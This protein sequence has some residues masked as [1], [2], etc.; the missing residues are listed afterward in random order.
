MDITRF[1]RSSQLPVTDGHFVTT[2]VFFFAVWKHLQSICWVRN[3]PGGAGQYHSCWFNGSL[4]CL[5]INNHIS[6]YAQWTDL[7]FACG[8]ITSTHFNV[9]LW[10]KIQI[11]FML[12]HNNSTCIMI[13]H[14]EAGGACMGQLYNWPSNQIKSNQIKFISHKYIDILQWIPDNKAYSWEVNQGSWCLSSWLPFKRKRK[15]MKRKCVMKI[16]IAKQKW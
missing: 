13:N 2:H 3:I 1:L 4:R 5:T 8:R 14:T 12:P 6:S 10:N 9:E 15:G 11:C 7:R 16:K